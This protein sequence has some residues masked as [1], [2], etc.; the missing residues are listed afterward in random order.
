MSESPLREVVQIS[1][2]T[3]DLDRFM[4]IWNDKYGVGPWEVLDFTSDRLSDATVDEKPVEYGMRLARARLGKNVVI[5]LME[6]LDDR[7]IYAISLNRHN[8]RDHVHHIMCTTDDYDAT[9]EHY[10]KI[11]VGNAMGGNFNGLEFAYLDTIEDLGI[12]IELSK[13]PSDFEIPQPDS[14]YP[15]GSASFTDRRPSGAES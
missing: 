14:V 5:E 10:K 12:W 6:P 4:R 7:S 8:G 13:V 9:L 3:H 1:F 15:L 11:G 2:A